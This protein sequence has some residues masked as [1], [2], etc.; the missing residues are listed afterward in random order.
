MSIVT[1]QKN[2]QYSQ[3]FFRNCP[4]D[5][6]CVNHGIG[7]LECGRVRKKLAKNYSLASGEE[8]FCRYFVA[9]TSPPLHQP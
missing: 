9:A 7:D 6:R 1:F 2:R 4:H 3:E 5:L 8:R